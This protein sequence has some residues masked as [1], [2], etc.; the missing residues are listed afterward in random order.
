MGGSEHPPEMAVDLTSE[1]T[2]AA[3]FSRPDA[4][5][6]PRDVRLD[7]LRGFQLQ[8]AGT[9]IELPLSAQ[10]VLAFLAL[11]RRPIARHFV[12]AML[13]MDCSE[14]RAGGN[15]RSAL[16]RANRP[17]HQLIDAGAKVIRIMPDV[18]VDLHEMTSMARDLL[19]ER[20]TSDQVAS[21]DLMSAEDLLPGWYDEW[22]VIERERFQQLRLHAL[23]VLCVQLADAGRFGQAVEAG[24]AAIASEPLRESAH[25]ALIRVYLAEGNRAEAIRQYTSCQAILRRELDLEPS[26]VTE[27]LIRQ[28]TSRAAATP[29]GGAT[30]R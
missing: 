3:G 4:P 19:D 14:E 28:L 12:A 17:G 5:I 27:S 23:E 29:N 11:Q 7:L 30:A 25:R 9:A 16:W 24:L 20:V 22:V 15:L 2:V 26:P 18:V 10:R 8:S 13:W 21:R 1:R 6:R